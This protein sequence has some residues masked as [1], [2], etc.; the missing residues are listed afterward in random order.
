MCVYV[1]F[2]RWSLQEKCLIWLVSRCDGE[3]LTLSSSKLVG[4][5]AARRRP[6]GPLGTARDRSGPAGT[7]RDQQGP[8]GTLGTSRGRSGPAEAAP[9]PAGRWATSKME[10]NFKETARDR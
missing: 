7:G 6:S 5:V 3:L 1:R 9:L 8:A 4:P 10:C 2:G